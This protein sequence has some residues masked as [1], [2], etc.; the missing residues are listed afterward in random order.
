MLNQCLQSLLNC[1]LTEHCPHF[2]I[3]QNNLLAGKLSAEVKHQ[4][5]EITC[6]L[7]ENIEQSLLAIQIDDLGNRL[8]VKSGGI[9]EVHFMSEYDNAFIVAT[10]NI[11]HIA[12][13]LRCA[14][15]WV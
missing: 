3:P 10:Q 6:K 13:S 11:F 2:I 12:Q 8:V 5:T 4:L 14:I 1:I 9:S 7:T 15:M